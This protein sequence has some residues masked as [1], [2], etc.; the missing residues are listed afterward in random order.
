MKVSG[1]LIAL[2]ALILFGSLSAAAQSPNKDKPEIKFR[3]AFGAIRGTAAPAKVVPV[4]ANTILSSGDKLK[5]MVELKKKCFVYLVHSNSQGEVTMLFPYAVKQFEADY[6]TARKYF[7]PKGD[8]W[9]QLD[10]KTGRETF[11]LIASDQRLLDIEYTYE[12]YV[13][14]E[15]GKKRELSEQMLAEINGIREQY[16][17]SSEKGE[18]LAGNDVVHRGFERATGSDPTDISTLAKEVAYNN[19]YSET[20]VVEHR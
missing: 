16:L 4:S 12:K 20:F 18:I 3:W 14:A 10:G 9:F 7:V 17:A 11:N 6:Q 15:P 19:I 2:L 1:I 5:F 8:A 13:S